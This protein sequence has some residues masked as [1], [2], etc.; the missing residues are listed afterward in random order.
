MLLSLVLDFSC[1]S[2]SQAFSASSLENNLHKLSIPQ[3]I[4][5]VRSQFKYTKNHQFPKVTV[6]AISLKEVESKNEDLP[7]R[8]AWRDWSNWNNW[9]QWGD[10]SNYQPPTSEPSPATSPSRES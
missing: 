1:Q 3:R 6:Q 4:D 5:R 8:N 9:S 10:W 2:S 7:W